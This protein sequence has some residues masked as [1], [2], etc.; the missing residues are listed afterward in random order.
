MAPQVKALATKLL[1]LEFDT[2]NPQVE[3]ETRVPQAGPQP[4]RMRDGM[5]PLTH[6]HNKY[7]NVNPI[8]YVKNM[9]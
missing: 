1:K 7:L 2:W 5:H 3:G 4:T 9:F 8:P 6:S